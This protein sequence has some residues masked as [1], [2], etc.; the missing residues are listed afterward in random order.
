VL[1]NLYFISQIDNLGIRVVP[2]NRN[3]GSRQDRLDLEESGG[4]IFG[5]R[6]IGPSLYGCR[7]GKEINMHSN[8]D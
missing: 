5:G 1:Y 2:L 3:I 8:L 4:R 7:F 6:G